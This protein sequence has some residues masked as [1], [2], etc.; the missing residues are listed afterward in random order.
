MTTEAHRLLD[1]LEHLVV[2]LRRELRVGEP[3]EPDWMMN[4]R[5]EIGVTEVAG[6]GP[7]EDSDRILEYHASTT[8]DA[9]HDEVPWCSSYVN[10]VML[11]A[12]YPGT[13]SAAARS[14]LQYGYGLADLKPG[15][16]CVFWRKSRDSRAGHVAFYVGGDMYL[17]GNQSDKVCI[18][19]QDRSR[20]IGIRWPSGKVTP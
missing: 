4:A 6:R 18:A 5:A 17:G 1:E 16:I 3:A 13:G 14:W 11:Q 8:L 12:G 20:I 7:G 19:E 15:A 9:K 2:K 10:F